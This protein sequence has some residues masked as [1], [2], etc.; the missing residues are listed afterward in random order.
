MKVAKNDGGGDRTGVAKLVDKLLLIEPHTTGSTVTKFSNGEPSTWVDAH[1]WFVD[2]KGNASAV[3]D[4]GATA[5]RFW[6]EVLVSQLKSSIGERLAARI[7]RPGAAY[8]FGDL[9]EEDV[10]LCEKAEA[11]L[12]AGADVF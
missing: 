9:D 6:S 3:G 8:L 11:A 10:M 5:V 7:I 4:D 12:I 2:R 1:C